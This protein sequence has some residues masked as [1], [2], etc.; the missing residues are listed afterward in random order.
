MCLLR[1][2]QEGTTRHKAVRQPQARACWVFEVGLERQLSADRRRYVDGL[3]AD[4]RSARG[5]AQPTEV[6]PSS[7]ASGDVEKP[8]NL[9]GQPPRQPVQPRRRGAAPFPAVLSDGDRRR[10]RRAAAG[11]SWPTRSCASR[12]RCA[13]SSI[14]IWKGHFGTGLVDT[15]S[16][17]GVAGERPTQPE[18]LDY[19]AQTLRR[20]RMSIKQLHRDIML[21]AVYQS[22][23]DNVA[24][25]SRKTRGNRLYW[26]VERRR[27]TAEQVR[28]SLLFVAGALDT[29]AGGP[30]IR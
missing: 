25:T 21:S 28:D 3:R 11:S 23:A 13:S 10:S 26:R 29:K 6:L 12:S 4:S 20:R 8:V 18:L 16:N 24:A 7:T 5:R 17:F 22:S 30:S 2:L 27:M 14:A 19:L 1:D 15:P 9:Q